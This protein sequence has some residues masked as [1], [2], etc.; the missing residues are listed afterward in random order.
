M[1]KVNSP[2]RVIKKAVNKKIAFEND[3]YKT[4]SYIERREHLLQEIVELYAEHQ[5]ST[6]ADIYWDM[7]ILS[8]RRNYIDYAREIET[9]SLQALGIGALSS[10]F[11]TYLMQLNV[12][13]QTWVSML[14]GIPLMLIAGAIAG[15]FVWVID[16]SLLLNRKDK[17][18]I[19]D[20]E[21]K[22]I[23]DC[24]AKQEA[25]YRQGQPLKESAPESIPISAHERPSSQQ[26]S[27]AACCPPVEIVCPAH[28]RAVLQISVQPDGGVKLCWKARRRS[29][30]KSLGE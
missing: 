15:F 4:V 29:S 22:I 7:E 1:W 6:K 18:N 21:K 23:I 28:S 20:F 13:L 11:V 8:D 17:Y 10:V 16:N 24:I 3:R 30:Q 9:S 25:E 26:S 27:A 5:D 12:E 14:L 19:A 2:G